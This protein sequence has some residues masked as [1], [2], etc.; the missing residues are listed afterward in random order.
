MK[1][2]LLLSAA[3]LA[4]VLAAAPA[5]AAETA[6]PATAN[7]EVDAVIV[8]GQGQ[9]RQVQT[10]K[11]DS[12]SLEA[13]GTSPLKA[14]DKLPGVTFQSADAFGAYEWSARISIRGFNQN[15]LGFTL[16]GV[17]LGD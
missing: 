8:I 9:S 5:F 12:I 14:I 10:L 15:Q 2:Q 13:A 16:D 17:P 7:T 6:T 1:H 3:S 11:D 4:L